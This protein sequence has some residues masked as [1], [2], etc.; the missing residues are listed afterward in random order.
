ML[1]EIKVFLLGGL[2]F[3]IFFHILAK[4]NL[5]DLYFLTFRKMQILFKPSD[6]RSVV[7]YRVSIECLQYQWHSVFKP[8]LE[9]F[10]YDPLSSIIDY[11]IT[12]ISFRNLSCDYFIIMLFFVW[13]RSTEYNRG[14]IKYYWLK[15][16]PVPKL[17][18]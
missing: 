9:I 12:S 5:P 13:T 2:I 1:P 8:V 15:Y 6:I 10:N 11:L 4:V 18:F 7:I 16:D 14:H 3:D 17:I